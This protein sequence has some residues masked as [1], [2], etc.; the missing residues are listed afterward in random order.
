MT[1]DAFE[2]TPKAGT[3]TQSARFRLLHTVQS[4]LL[5]GQKITQAAIAKVIDIS[6]QAVSKLLNKAGL[7]LSELVKLAEKIL[8]P[9]N[10]T[11][12]TESSY[13]DGCIPERLYNDPSV[14]AL[15]D[16]PPLELMA[17]IIEAIAD[18]GWAGFEMDALPAPE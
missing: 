10:T 13:R 15:L 5:T 1:R 12:S 4:V 18:L 8:P 17:E 14:R 9:K 7:T 11:P 2:V 3:Q 6:Q 16:L